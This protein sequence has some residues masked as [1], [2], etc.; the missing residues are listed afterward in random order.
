MS[1][2]KELRRVKRDIGLEN[3]YQENRLYKLADWV[4]EQNIELPGE[5]QRLL[6]DAECGRNKL[7]K[8]NV[9]KQNLKFDIEVLGR[10]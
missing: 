7:N 3:M 4:K 2:D 8:L 6:V 1:D 10:E 5:I 9:L